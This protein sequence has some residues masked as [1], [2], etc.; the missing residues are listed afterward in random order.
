[1]DIECEINFAEWLQIHVQLVSELYGTVFV[2]KR[3]L[4]VTNRRQESQFSADS[5]WADVWWVVHSRRGDETLY[6]DVVSALLQSNGKTQY[7]QRSVRTES[8]TSS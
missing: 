7:S 1:M 4:T 2:Q 5:W 3:M 6:K 8:S